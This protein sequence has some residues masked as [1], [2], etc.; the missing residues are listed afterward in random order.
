M[1]ATMTMEE[2]GKE[3]EKMAKPKATRPYLADLI[4]EI[5][6]FEVS[7]GNRYPYVTIGCDGKPEIL[8][9]DRNTALM[10]DPYYTGFYAE[11]GFKPDQ[12][13]VQMPDARRGQLAINKPVWYIMIR[14][15]AEFSNA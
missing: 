6:A 8:A 10:D 11:R 13:T 9:V 4:K 5:V 1:V 12:V 14:D 2:T 15:V 3:T 7:A